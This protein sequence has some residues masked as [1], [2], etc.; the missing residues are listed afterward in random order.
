MKNK[1]YITNSKNSNNKIVTKTMCQ[2]CFGSNETL[3]NKFLY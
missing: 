3:A 1:F 2:Y